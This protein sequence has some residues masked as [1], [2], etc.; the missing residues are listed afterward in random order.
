VWFKRDV[1]PIL[2]Q[3]ETYTSQHLSDENTSED[4]FE[5]TSSGTREIL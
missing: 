1:D 2:E 3:N 4:D 5:E